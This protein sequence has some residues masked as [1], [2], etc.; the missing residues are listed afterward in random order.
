MLTGHKQCATTLL[1][2]ALYC[3][4]RNDLKRTTIHKNILSPIKSFERESGG[5]GV[6]IPGL[7]GGCRFSEKSLYVFTGQLQVWQK[8]GIP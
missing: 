2:I 3:F 8:G 1:S 7:V 4:G 5:L 6:S